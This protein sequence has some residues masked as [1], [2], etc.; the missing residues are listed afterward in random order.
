MTTTGTCMYCNQVIILDKEMEQKEADERAIL[1]CKCEGAKHHKTIMARCEKARDNIEL[2]LYEVDEKACE[3]LKGCVELV[4][5]HNIAKIVV[6]TGRNVK[7]TVSRTSKDTI[8][9]QRKISKE[10]TF[11]E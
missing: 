1:L 2:A 5:K 10:V 11:D 4:A 9:V 7:V 3:Y 6:D 8:K